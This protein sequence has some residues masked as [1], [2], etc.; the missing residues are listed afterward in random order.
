MKL[1][2][3]VRDIKLED[4]ADVFEWAAAHHSGDVVHVYDDDEPLGRSEMTDPIWRI[5]IV[6]ECGESLRIQMQSEESHPM[7]L[8][9]DR[10]Y[11]R[12]RRA[13]KLDW[14][15]ITGTDFLA[16]MADDRRAHGTF[17][18]PYLVGSKHL[19]LIVKPRIKHPDEA[20]TVL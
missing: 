17:I 14:S 16:Y 12:Q 2:V 1:L 10:K 3:C 4:L 5:L 11:P 8:R 18:L 20:D 9:G 15:A 19:K 13:S 7:N 6:H